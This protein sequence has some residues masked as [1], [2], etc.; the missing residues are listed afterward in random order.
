[1]RLTVAPDA[2]VDVLLSGAT[3][4]VVALCAVTWALSAVLWARVGMW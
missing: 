4:L 2:N 1:V 3:F